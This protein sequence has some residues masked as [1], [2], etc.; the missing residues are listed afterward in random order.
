M[1]CLILLGILNLNSK[2]KLEFR[3]ELENG[4]LKK[5]KDQLLP[6]PTPPNPINRSHLRRPTYHLLHACGPAGGGL[7]LRADTWAQSTVTRCTT[8]LTASWG[9]PLIL[10]PS[11]MHGRVCLRPPHSQLMGGS[12]SS[13]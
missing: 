8:Q 9:P 1:F 5:R 12:H 11:H 6:R 3:S 2:S 7:A 13:A 4:K 10:H